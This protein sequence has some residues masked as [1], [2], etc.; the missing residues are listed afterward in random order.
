MTRPVPATLTGSVHQLVQEF[1]GVFAREAV[2]GCVLDS[3]ERLQPG[4]RISTLLP[5]LAH[6]FARKRLRSCGV[7]KGVLPK[8]APVVLFV[9][10]HNAGRSQLA[11]ALLAGAAGDRVRIASAGTTPA[12]AVDPVVLEVLAERGV[13]AGDAYPTPLTPEVVESADVVIT[14]GCG[15]SCPVLPGRRYLDWD[16]ADPAGADL[17]TVRAIR[18]DIEGRV[19]LL[20]LELLPT[21]AEATP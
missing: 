10:T 11:A 9:C 3:Y 5:L 17:D 20:L 16:L 15:D 1:A 7:A 2:Q 6:R 14:M 4:A 8:T 21:T 12:P 13:D 18:D 19:Q